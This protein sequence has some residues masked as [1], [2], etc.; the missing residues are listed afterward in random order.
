M[1]T[2]VK[3][4]RGVQ[5][6]AKTT[7]K[8]PGGITGKGFMPGESGNPGGRPSLKPITDRYRKI[9]AW[10]LPEKV[11]RRL[12]L[13]EGATY[14]DALALSVFEESGPSAAR[15]VRE[16]LEGK[17]KQRLEITGEDGAP[18]DIADVRAKL[19]EKLGSER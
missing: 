9:A 3:R 2:K 12:G 4:K 6:N 19:F 16:A 14:G 15:E 17:A 7:Q 13:P 18:V 8:L 11:R 5:N 10:P 1:A